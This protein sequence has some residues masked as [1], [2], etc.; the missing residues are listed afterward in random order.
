MKYGT[1]ASVLQ[2]PL[3]QVF[4]IAKELGFDGVELDWFK[5]EDA[6]SGDLAPQKRAALKQAARNA[7]IEISSVAAHFL[8]GGNVESSDKAT[9]S[10]ARDSIMEG[11]QLCEDLG[12]P[13]LLVPFF[14]DA[15][16]LD[17]EAKL[18]VI[19]ALKELAPEAER[20]RVK[21]AIEH[22][23]RGDEAARVLDQVASPWVGNY[24]DMANGMSLGYAPL[25][26]ICALSKHLF[27]VHAKEFSGPHIRQKSG[28]YPGLNEVPF[29]E[30][31]V[32]L[33]DILNALSEIGYND[34]ITLETG[35]FGDAKK[36]AAEAL[37]VLKTQQ[38]KI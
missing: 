9:Q 23:L 35:G 13:V 38:L 24:W 14:G 2:E 4:A 11:L 26:D 21:I 20:R 5:R 22:T 28:E 27:R 18:R 33:D 25:D 15:E 37:N 32:P 30:G 7:D 10:Q 34:I 31:D 1:L 36:S 3:P 12:A 19:S 16:I 17:D 6:R 8:N 29:G